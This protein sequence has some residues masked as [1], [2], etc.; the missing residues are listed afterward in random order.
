MRSAVFLR[1]VVGKTQHALIIGVG[2]LQSG[3]NADVVFF[4]RNGND[5]LMQRGFGFVD[6]VDKGL[7]SAFVVHDRFPG[8][9][10]AV[11]N[12]FQINAG[13]QK[14][15]FANGAFQSIKIKLGHGKS[16][17]RGQEGN[18]GAMLARGFAD[19][20]QMLGNVAV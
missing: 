14:R 10:A 7:K 19:D 3:I 4:A 11:V 12:Q 6:V 13:V 16:F 9:A 8:F 20:F 18:F 17:F 1:N 15:L 2:P 5:F